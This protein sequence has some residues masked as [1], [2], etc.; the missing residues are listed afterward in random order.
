[1]PVR[2]ATAAEVTA[3]HGPDHMTR[4]ANKSAL[5]GADAMAGGAGRTHFSPDTYLNQHTL[6]C[7]HLAAGA[8]ADVAASVV[9]YSFLSV[10]KRF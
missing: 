1:M 8:C 2:E 3:C 9:R 6:L 4:V 10:R 5:A 7:A